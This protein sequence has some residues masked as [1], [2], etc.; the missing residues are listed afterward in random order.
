MKIEVLMPKMGESITEGRI[1]RWLKKPGDAIERDETI[2]EIS[3]DKVDTEV[4]APEKGIVVQLLAGENDTVEVNKPIALIE[5]DAASAHVIAEVSHPPAAFQPAA[6]ETAPAE[7]APQ[8]AATLPSRPAVVPAPAA[9]E[10]PAAEAPAGRRFYSPVV[11]RIAADEGIGVAE[12]ETIPGT[13]LNGRVTKTDLTAYVEKRKQEAAAPRG[14]ASVEIIR[15]N[16][17]RS[18]TP[19]PYGLPPDQAATE[20]I[21]MDNLHRLMAEHMVRSKQTSPHVSLVSE[22]DITP[23]ARYREEQ[24]AAFKARE[25]YALTFMPF[26]AD[27][28]IRA[29]KD[30]P[31]VNASVQGTDIILKKF[32]NLGIAVAL[33]S[34]GLI[35]PVIRN[36]ETLNLV[37]LARAIHDMASRARTK[38]LR[39]EEIQEGTFTITNYGVFGNLFGTP[40]I[41]QPQVAILGVGTAQKRP[42]VIERDGMELI[43]VRTMMYLSL[44]FDHRLVDGALG[45]M[46]LERTVR[47]LQE[48]RP[49]ASL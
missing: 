5:T 12:L 32:V 35:V 39:P 23:I 34:G 9:A 11:M 1:I 28:A 45:G 6:V 33:E 31:F 21:P 47:Y 15:A 36:A 4:P 10:A 41:N 7:P 25:G 46:Y 24:A 16:V 26:I 38:R 37:G 19:A 49:L 14:T 42:V 3:T 43:A 27:A 20:V 48:F 40:I 29:L 17:V 22:V 13:G 30:F 2:V 8:P 44:S 18:E